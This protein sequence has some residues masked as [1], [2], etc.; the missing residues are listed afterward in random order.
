ML[1]GNPWHRGEKPIG[2]VGFFFLIMKAIYLQGQYSICLS[3]TG[4]SIWF[5][6]ELHGKRSKTP[7]KA[8]NNGLGREE[9]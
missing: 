5:M 2:F 4:L 3:L 8:G 9:A 1:Q 7:S 6:L